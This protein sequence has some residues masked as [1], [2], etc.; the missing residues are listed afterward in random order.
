[1]V[2]SGTVEHQERAL[3]KGERK[4]RD[5][6]QRRACAA[7]K[8]KPGWTITTKEGGCT[9]FQAPITISTASA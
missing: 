4:E 1:M 8:A 3:M 6:K 2:R 7:S 9:V 5:D